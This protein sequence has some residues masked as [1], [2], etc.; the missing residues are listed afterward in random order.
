M[1]HPPSPPSLLPHLFP[2]PLPASL[3]HPTRPSFHPHADASHRPDQTNTHNCHR[4]HILHMSC[5]RHHHW[6]AAQYT[7]LVVLHRLL[8]LMFAATLVVCVDQP[9]SCWAATWCSY[10]PTAQTRPIHRCIDMQS[11]AYSRHTPPHG[12]HTHTDPAPCSAKRVQ[13]SRCRFWHQ[14]IQ[15]IIEQG[16][17]LSQES[18]ASHI[19]PP[20]TISRHPHQCTP[21]V[22]FPVPSCHAG[23]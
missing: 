12:L 3:A 20:H 13:V 8:M 1:P 2:S 10:H 19:A 16:P 11:T 18:C 15:I 22:A 17:I 14:A 23:H 4:L 5:T 6:H 7:V 21:A 9:S